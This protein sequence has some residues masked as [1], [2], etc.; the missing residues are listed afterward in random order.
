MPD[1]LK[2]PVRRASVNS[3]LESVSDFAGRP[4]GPVPRTRLDA[5]GNASLD[6]FGQC[7]D[8]VGWQLRLGRHV[9]RFAVIDGVDQKAFPGVAGHNCRAG[10]S[11]GDQGGACVEPQS[12][13][14]LRR[15]VTSLAP[16]G[17][18]RPNALLEK[19]D[20]SG[21]RFRLGC[22]PG[23]V[24]RPEPRP[25]PGRAG[26]SKETVVPVIEQRGRA[27]S[28]ASRS[29]PPRGTLIQVPCHSTLEA[30][31]VRTCKSARYWILEDHSVVE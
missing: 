12:P 18:N 11:A 26:K 20:R 13:L 25:R 7:G 31:R 3:S 16:R 22:R 24:R 19:L 6:P 9:V 2:A 5:P 4:G 23:S 15:S 21:I 8:L 17:Q 29:L 10:R 28:C 27:V 1:R 30:L 14:L